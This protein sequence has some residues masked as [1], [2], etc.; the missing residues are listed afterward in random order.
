MMKIKHENDE[1][2]EHSFEVIETKPLDVQ[3][4]NDEISI[5]EEYLVKNEG[6]NTYEVLKRDNI[7]KIKQENDEIEEHSFE[8]SFGVIEPEP[9][10]VQFIK[11]EI[12]T[13]EEYLVKIEFDNTYDNSFPCNETDTSKITNTMSCNSIETNKKTSQQNIDKIGQFDCSKCQRRF[14]TKINI[15]RHI[16]KS[17]SNNSKLKKVPKKNKVNRRNSS[18]KG[19]T[20][21]K[22]CLINCGI[23][24]KSFSFKSTLRRHCRIHTD[25]ER[26]KCDVCEKTF[27]HQASF[28]AHERRHTG[29]KPFECNICEKT[30]GRQYHLKIHKRI[31]TGERPFKCDICEKTF[32]HQASFR[33]HER[34]HTGE[35][36]FKCDVCEKTSD[37]Q[38]DLK[39]HK[40]IHIGGVR[41]KCAVC[42]TSYG[43]Q[44]TLKSHQA[45]AH[46]S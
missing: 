45:K 30:F 35:K 41:Y 27:S 42:G 13:T 43:R 34:T 1:T 15:T 8:K 37:R 6:D 12:S 22:D 20:Q 16:A 18:I 38:Y 46:G 39:R 2:E 9:F 29:E 3:F 19:Y 21:N 17:H 31:H 14:A 7:L 24:L 36:R 25:E 11:N 32:G 40:R 44:D 4:K 26:F 33:T 5:T 23:C 10:D 28:R